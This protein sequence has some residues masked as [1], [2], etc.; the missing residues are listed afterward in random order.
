MQITPLQKLVITRFKAA[1]LDPAFG[2]SIIEHESAWDPNA[3]SAPTAS[4]EKYGGAWG[5]AQ[6]LKITA[7]KLGYTGAPEGLFDPETNIDL[8]IKLTKQNI[9]TFKT[10]NTND[11]IAMHNSGLPLSLLQR[12]SRR[13]ANVVAYLDAVLKIYPKWESA[14]GDTVA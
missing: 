3:R 11:L 10:T 13:F 12:N 8:F 4:D 2:C 6:L 1:N 5:L 9:K 7:Y 14:V